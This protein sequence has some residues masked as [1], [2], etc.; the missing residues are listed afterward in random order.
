MVAVVASGC[1]WRQ[2]GF[3]P[4]RTGYNPNE[5]T[6]TAANVHT[7]QQAW[8]AT[9]PE[10][11]NPPAVQGNNVHIT[12]GN[13]YT[14]LNGTDGSIYWQETITQ[15]GLD[16]FLRAPA[17]IGD[18]AYVPTAAYRQG[19]TLV[20]DP[21]TKTF[22]GS[23][24][25]FGSAAPASTLAVRSDITAG[26][27]GS[28]IPFDVLWEVTY[29]SNTGF[30]D[31]TS[32]G[33]PAP[34]DPAIIGTRVFVGY[35]TYVLSYPIGTCLSA[36]PIPGCAPETRRD[37]GSNVSMPV[38]V[39]ATHVAV[40]TASGDVVVLN[41]ADGTTAYSADLGT[42]KAQSPAVA[43]NTIYAATE[44]G[45]LAALPTSGCT[46]CTPLWTADVGA[47]IFTQPTVAGGVVYVGAADGKV[48]AF[49][50]AGCGTATCAEL[51][52]ATVD[53]N[54]D[55]IAVV[56]NNGRVYVTADTGTVKAYKLP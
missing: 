18:K 38:G 42:A 35:T 11:P 48:H 16:A 4:E 25:P 44:A 24:S 2:V 39:D 5:S 23:F 40:G 30:I 51:W 20:F 3:G 31:F 33:G 41:A 9:V 34:S 36:P 43:N 27:S 14:D 37:V 19:A 26:V 55:R 46:T 21:A 17:V 13:T 52:S 54:A 10:S 32:L 53:A 22:T 47:A 7:L 15:G 56:V 1:G 49:N 50:A 29:G 6:V 45:K 8:S 28:I 12:A